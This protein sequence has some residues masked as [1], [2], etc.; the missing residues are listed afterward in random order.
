MEPGS[1]AY[2]GLRQVLLSHP[3]RFV[4]TLTENLLA[5]AVGRSLEYYDQP[6]VRTVVR[7]SAPRDYRFSELVL[8]I[9]NSPAFLEQEGRGSTTVEWQNRIR[10]RN[11]EPEETTS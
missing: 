8:G 4:S 1:K 6:V 7:D 2:A 11:P 9:V 5:Y 3:E 10:N